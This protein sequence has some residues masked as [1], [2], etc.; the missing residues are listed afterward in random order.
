MVSMLICINI[1]VGQTA[2]TQDHTRK[3][4]AEFKTQAGG[5]STS[6]TTEDV[7]LNIDAELLKR[8]KMVYMKAMVI[9]LVPLNNTLHDMHAGIVGLPVA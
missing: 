1:S 4:D 8:I 7:M 3:N 6:S 9:T 5:E 2:P